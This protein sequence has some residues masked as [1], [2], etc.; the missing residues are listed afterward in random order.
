MSNVKFAAVVALVFFTSA[1]FVNRAFDT[2]ER[3]ARRA[4]AEQVEAAHRKIVDEQEQR[5]YYAL[6]LN[7]I[8]AGF[9]HE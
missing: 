9:K 3:A 2:P 5:A 7:D 1:A 8:R 4:A 6:K